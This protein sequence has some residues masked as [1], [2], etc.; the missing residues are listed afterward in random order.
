M[1]IRRY[2]GT[3]GVRGVAG[4][5]PM[6]VGFALR[7]GVATAE[8]MRRA[9]HGHPHVLIGMDTRR[10]GPMLAHAAAAGLTSRGAT[11]TWLGVVPTP[12]VSY[13]TRALGADAGLMVSASHNPFH[14]NGLKLFD[15]NGEKLSDEV[16]ASIEE[17]I[18]Q[19]AAD[20]HAGLEPITGAE[21]GVMEPIDHAPL[22]GGSKLDP[23]FRHLLENAPYLDGMRVA[24]DCA[25]G[26]SYAI[27]PQLFAKIGARVEVLNVEPDGRNIN[28]DCGSTHPDALA[29][30][31]VEGGFDVGV[32]F[33]GDADRALL[34]DS[35]GRLVS[36]DHIIAIAALSRGE[37]EVVATV[38]T[39]LGTERYLAGQG[40]KLHRVKVGDR[41]V[42]EELRRR[43][44]KVGGEQSG[45]VLFLDKAPTGD[46]ML[47][48]LV[49]LSAV[50]KSGRS[51][52]EWMD[53]I[54]VYPQLLVNVPVPPGLRDHL[55][56]VEDVRAAVAEAEAQLG[57]AGRVLLRPSG[58]EPLVR[59]MV[60]G[61]QPELVEGT[62][63]RI[64]DAVRAAAAPLL[65]GGG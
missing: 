37:R 58:T 33:D 29:R 18:D 44:L 26:A 48:A 31:V 1:A 62:A 4:E 32:T 2:F 28:V 19:L 9:G 60:E 17:L 42:F 51:L 34:I 14:D 54:P 49:A 15:A 21:V 24:L 25:H 8:T 38:M 41:Y 46:G 52:E 27:A 16:E 40:V 45:H 63:Q 50:R 12:G 65:Q 6:T 13:L 43:D 22:G 47:T 3:D 35:K 53:E 30:R 11:V 36:G 56:E 61:E 64:A 10:S 23:Y 39:N 5:S 7:L 55:S 20:E 57:A 59:V